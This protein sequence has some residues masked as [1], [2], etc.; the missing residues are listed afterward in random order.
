MNG[1]IRNALVAATLATLA[2]GPVSAREPVTDLGTL[3]G[4]YS[5]A[6]AI[7][8]RGQVVGRSFT[9]DGEVHAVLWT[10]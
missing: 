3:G 4:T 1:A 7:S 5:Q 2:A 6:E 10:T 8:N 9:T